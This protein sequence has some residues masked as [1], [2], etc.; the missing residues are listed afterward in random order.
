METYTQ[1]QKRYVKTEIMISRH[2]E[3]K[4]GRGC[5]YLSEVALG[6]RKYDVKLL[7]EFSP[8]HR[9]LLFARCKQCIESEVK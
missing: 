1:D 2:G 4:C 5:D 3:N 8:M 9:E 6:C 7:N